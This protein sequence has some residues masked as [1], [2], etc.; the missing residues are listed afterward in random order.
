MKPGSTLNSFVECPIPSVRNMAVVI[1]WFIIWSVFLLFIWFLL[2]V[3]KVPSVLACNSDFIY[4]V[5]T[6]VYYCPLYSLVRLC[7]YT[8]ISNLTLH[9]NQSN[10]T[11]FA[12]PT[13]RMK[14]NMKNKSSLLIFFIHS[15]IIY[16]SFPIRFYIS[17]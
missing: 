11:Y 15:F 3:D 1:K 2:V 17:L 6:P 14:E 10:W 4:D 9:G 13:H 7:P 12:S 8:S 5:W 16:T